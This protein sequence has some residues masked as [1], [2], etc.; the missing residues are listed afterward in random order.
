MG[1]VIR[2]VC[3]IVVRV[4]EEVVDVGRV[5]GRFGVGWELG[6][7]RDVRKH[8]VEEIVVC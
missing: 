6:P 1:A 5:V 7:G 2:V 4:F 8:L 3:R